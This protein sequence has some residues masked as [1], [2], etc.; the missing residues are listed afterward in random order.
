MA[1]TR[2]FFEIKGRHRHDLHLDLR[3]KKIVAET[4]INWIIGRIKEFDVTG[5]QLEKSAVIAI[6]KPALIEPIQS[7]PFISKVTPKRTPFVSKV[8]TSAALKKMPTRI[9]RPMTGLARPLY[10]GLR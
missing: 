10:R 6:K 4:Y 7:T 3:T 9:V 8:T 5:K 1:T 2:I